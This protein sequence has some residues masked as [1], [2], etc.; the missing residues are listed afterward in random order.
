MKD[1]SKPKTSTNGAEKPVKKG[2]IGALVDAEKKARRRSSLGGTITLPV[3]Q[4]PGQSIL[5]IGLMSGLTKK[6]LQSLEKQFSCLE[7]EIWDNL[8]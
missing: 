1:D 8:A 4:I 5:R 6:K 3:P 7:M 2:R